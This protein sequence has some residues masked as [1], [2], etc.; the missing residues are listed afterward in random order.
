M[1]ASSRGMG[2]VIV[3]AADAFNS[4]KLFSMILILVIVSMTLVT[5]LRKSEEWIAPWRE[6]SS[7]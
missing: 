7:V 2:Y 6:K 1:L 5:L 3:R 4:A